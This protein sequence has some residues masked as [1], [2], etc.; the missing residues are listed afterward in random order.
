MLGFFK[1][2][3]FAMLA[4][5]LFGAL[6]LGTAAAYAIKPGDRRYE[7]FKAL[8][9]ATLFSTL[10]GVCAGIATVM[11]RVPTSPEWS[12]SPDINLVIMIGL[13]ESLANCIL[14]FALLAVSWFV[15]AFGNRRTA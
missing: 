7:R 4:I 10:A 11:H 1:E 12:H 2:G 3:G 15:F 13:G 9:A 6:T 8:A 5:L 14:G